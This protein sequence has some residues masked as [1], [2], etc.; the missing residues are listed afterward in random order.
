MTSR[1][2]SG[3]E[4]IDDLFRPKFIPVSFYPLTRL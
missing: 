2:V 4:A 3:C 1:Y